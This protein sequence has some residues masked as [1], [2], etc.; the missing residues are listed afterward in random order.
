M[1]PRLGQLVKYQSINMHI[2]NLKNIR[3]ATQKQ[4][5]LEKKSSTCSSFI[6]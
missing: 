3:I 2:V 1:Y 5:E 6:Q 4:I